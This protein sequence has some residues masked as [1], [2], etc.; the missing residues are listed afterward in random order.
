MADR[1][2]WEDQ[3]KDLKTGEAP[4]ELLSRITTVVPHLAQEKAAERPAQGAFLRFVSEWRYGLALKVAAF[5]CVAVLGVLAGSAGG[6]RDSD[7]LGSLIFGDI[8]W[9]SAI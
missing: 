1:R 7:P 3:V 8:G 6:A 5:A 2:T 4:A 9:E